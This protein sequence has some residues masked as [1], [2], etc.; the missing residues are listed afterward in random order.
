MRGRPNAPIEQKIARGRLSKADQLRIL[1]NMPERVE[2]TPEPPG[3]MAGDALL[4]WYRFSE[5]LA[6][7]GQ[8]SQ[9]T[10]AALTAMC[11]VYGQ[12]VALQKDISANGFIQ[13]IVTDN[14]PQEK[15]RPSYQAFA[16]ADRRLRYWLTEF[17]LTDATRG[18]VAAPEPGETPEEDPLKRYGL[19]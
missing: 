1:K 8:L 13:H 5:L 7:R 6:R 4:G 15:I 11:V 19:Q 12:W 2:G 17:G 16:D 3:W 10:E 18:K 14:G 9:E